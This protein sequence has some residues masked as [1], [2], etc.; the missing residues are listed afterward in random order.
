[1]TKSPALIT[2]ANILKAE[3]TAWNSGD[4]CHDLASSTEA[5]N[6]LLDDAYFSQGMADTYGDA[7]PYI[8]AKGAELIAAV[9]TQGLDSCI[10][11]GDY[12]PEDEQIA[13]RVSLA[14]MDVLAEVAADTQAVAQDLFQEIAWFDAYSAKLGLGSLYDG[15]RDCDPHSRGDVEANLRGHIE[16]QLEAA[17]APGSLL[18]DE[19]WRAY[20]AA[21]RF[22]RIKSPAWSALVD[23][24]AARAAELFAT[25]ID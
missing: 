11:H 9:A 22:D 21:E 18:N 19:Q 25:E 3:G 13:A 4:A 12:R 7:A 15:L 14:I 23:L 5:R 2:L 20:A 17:R 8:A 10:F 1:M 16:R 6:L 24:A